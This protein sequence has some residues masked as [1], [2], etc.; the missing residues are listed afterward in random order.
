VDGNGCGLIGGTVMEFVWR[1]M[2]K[3]AGKSVCRPKFAARPPE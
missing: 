1:D 2:C 3:T